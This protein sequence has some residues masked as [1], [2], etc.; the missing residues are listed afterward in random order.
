MMANVR[1][2]GTG[3]LK[4]DFKAR[5]SRYPLEWVLENLVW[6]L[7]ELP[8][9]PLF[10]YEPRADSVAQLS[11]GDFIDLTTQPIRYRLDL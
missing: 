6:F 1:F 5:T 9:M 4:I 10:S 11:F 7:R 3:P 2:S 8:G